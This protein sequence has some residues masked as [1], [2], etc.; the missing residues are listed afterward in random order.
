[1]RV[2]VLLVIGVVQCQPFEM[3]VRMGSLDCAD[4]CVDEGPLNCGA[5]GHV[6]NPE[7]PD[8]AR[9]EWGARKCLGASRYCERERICVSQGAYSDARCRYR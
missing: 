2:G 3:C 5:C 6:C 8:D 7:S 9:C 4:E 1:M